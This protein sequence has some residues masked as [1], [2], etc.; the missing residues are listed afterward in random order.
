MWKEKLELLQGFRDVITEV[1][2][3]NALAEAMGVNESH[4]MKNV[5]KKTKNK[6][7]HND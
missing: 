1:F 4:N 5:D 3:I 6:L 2:H 7:I